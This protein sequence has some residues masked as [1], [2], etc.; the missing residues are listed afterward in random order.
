MFLNVFD[1]FYQHFVDFFTF[2]SRKSVNLPLWDK[3]DTLFRVFSQI[4]NFYSCF[5]SFPPGITKI[6]HDHANLWRF[7]P[8]KALMAWC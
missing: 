4:V 5:V 1:D 7:F 3:F 8:E 2:F 6:D